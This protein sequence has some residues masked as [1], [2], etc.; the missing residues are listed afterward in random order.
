MR[1]VIPR[2]M[3]ETK[4]EEILKKTA[5]FTRESSAIDLCQMPPMRMWA[6]P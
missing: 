1:E 6:E 5:V 3:K 2:R 4:N